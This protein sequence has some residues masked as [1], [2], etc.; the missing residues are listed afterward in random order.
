M[1]RPSTLTCIP[2]DMPTRQLSVPPDGVLG[3]TA[4]GG[5]VTLEAAPA[6]L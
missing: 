2:P 5:G 3:A 4:V 6:P 1:L